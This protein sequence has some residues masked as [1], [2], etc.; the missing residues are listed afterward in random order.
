MNNFFQLNFI[1]HQ[2]QNF[3]TLNLSKPKKIISEKAFYILL[4]ETPSTFLICMTIHTSKNSKVNNVAQ[5]ARYIYV[6][7]PFCCNQE[8]LYEF[9]DHPSAPMGWLLM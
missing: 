8:P 9:I 6:I 4:T 1:K 2:T 3:L 7:K 5:K